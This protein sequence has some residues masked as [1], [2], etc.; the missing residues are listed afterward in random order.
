MKRKRKRIGALLLAASLV[1]GQMGMNV[2]AEGTNEDNVG[3]CEHHPVHTAE[4]GYVKAQPGTPC[5]HEH[6][7]SCYRQEENCVHEHMAECY[8]EWDGLENDATPSNAGVTEAVECSHIC[9]IGDADT[10]CIAE[11]L[12]CPHEHDSDCGYADGIEGSPC[13]YR[14]E[15]CNP[16][17]GGDGLKNDLALANPLPD[18]V[19]DAAVI[20]ITGFDELDMEEQNRLVP[21]GTEQSDLNLPV[22]LKASGY[23]AKGDAVPVTES[24]LVEGVTWEIDPDNWANDGNSEYHPEM[25]SYCFTPI[26]PHKYELENGVTLPEIYV[27]IDGQ[28]VIYDLS[29]Y[30]PDDVAAINAIIQDNDLPASENAPEEWASTG[31]IGWDDSSPKRVIMLSLSRANLIGELDVTALDK[32]KW[33]TCDYT[34]LTSLKVANLSALQSLSCEGNRLTSLDVT[35]LN[36]LWELNCTNNQ[37]TSLNVTGLDRLKVLGCAIN[38]LSSLDVSGRNRLEVLYCQN[39]QLTS[40]EVSDLDRLRELNCGN[41]QLPSLDLSGLNSLEW[42]NCENNKLS[43]L[44]MTGLS[45]LQTLYC[46]NNRLTSLDA[47][48]QPA[49]KMLHCTDN[50]LTSLNVSGLSE[51]RE[52]Q[53]MN[54]Q[55]SSLNL[56]G[57]PNFEM[58]SC[59]NNRLTSL[60]LSGLPNLRVLYCENNQLSSLDL[61]GKDRLWWLYCQNNQLSSLNLSGL[62][63]LLTLSCENN[64]FVSLTTKNGDTL[65]TD[66]TAGGK[67]VTTSYDKGSSVIELTAVPDDGYRF[68]K[69]N[70]AFDGAS[71]TDNKMSFTL[72]SDQTVTAEFIDPD[73]AMLKNLTVTG[74]T[75][76][77]AFDPAVVSY[78]GTV[79]NSVSS[80]TITAEANSDYAV[81][82]GTGEKSLNVG[83]NIFTVTVTSEDN[84][85]TMSYTI[86]ITRKEAESNNSE[87]HDSHIGDDGSDSDHDSGSSGNGY[88]T[89]RPPDPLKPDTVTTGVILIDKAD[90]DGKVEIPA[91]QVKEAMKE[92]ALYA[93]K[94]GSAKGGAA[95]D[96]N[97][98]AV[99]ASAVLNRA[100]LDQMISS[101][102][103]N[104]RLNFG[105]ASMSFDLAALKEIAAQITGDVTFGAKKAEGLSGDAAAAIGT[106]PVYDFTVTGQKD[107]KTAAVTQLGAGQVTLTFSYPLA[108]GQQMSGM[109]LVRLEQNGAVTWLSQFGFDSGVKCLTGAAGQIGIYGVGYKTPPASP[110][111]KG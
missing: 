27:K 79:E 26:L 86:S 62:N 15:I 54:N 93:Q 13:G 92:A 83:P 71:I 88:I 7:G 53:C 16:R 37:L 105:A 21:A 51:L 38:E 22:T 108:E 106:R 99:A 72:D 74:V 6:T 68:K 10:D 102:I 97:L 103:K 30:H 58:L 42:L 94:A 12:D 41:N 25:G 77:E 101:G 89:V 24:L 85:T 55:L 81:V 31:W 29:D 69:W 20:R 90:K 43:S 47:S 96:V 63:R 1:F 110:D 2:Y 36:S 52:V 23:T 76:N 44:D 57:L 84:T 75:L 109:Y 104:F 60:N 100:D 49:L 64:P 61:S 91:G 50:R 56:S 95:V 18:G 45:A 19:K 111:A 39:N 73:D 4:C 40:L 107:G 3:L 78:T 98:P 8:P 14:C 5:S 70:A 9:S 28:T 65:T 80:V 66:T 48:G 17:E 34:Q 33:F 87:N 67:V 11:V 35:G 59:Q 46:G 82:T 32:L